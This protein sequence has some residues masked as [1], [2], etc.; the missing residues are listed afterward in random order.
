MWDGS[1]PHWPA[2]VEFGKS[3]VAG[4]WKLFVLNLV[5]VFSYVW[6]DVCAIGMECAL[7]LGYPVREKPS[8]YLLKIIDEFTVKW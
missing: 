8:V 3:E 7:C 1:L 2:G 4:D 6:V 5:C